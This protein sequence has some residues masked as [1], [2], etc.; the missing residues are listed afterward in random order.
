MANA[1]PILFVSDSTSDTNLPVALSGDGHSVTTV[2]NDFSTGNTTL[3]GSL[4]LYDAVFWSATGTG[5]GG[6]HSAA[7]IANLHSYVTGGGRLF[8]TGYDALVS[9]ND[10]A[11]R[12]LLGGDAAYYDIG[13]NGVG[14]VTTDTNTL[15]AGVVAIAG[16]TTSTN[17]GNSDHDGLRPAGP[18]TACSLAHPTAGGGGVCLWSL[19]DLGLGQTAWVSSGSYN[20]RSG[21]GWLVT[22]ADGTG[23]FNAAARNFAHNAAASQSVPEPGTLALLAVGFGCMRMYRRRNGVRRV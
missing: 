20:G 18:D 19:R 7:V 3:T 5:Y 22:A 1:M 14:V 2:L 17:N 6:V 4:S 9:P 21:P 13:W 12:T 8:V 15:T 10:P 11:L 16:V 23:V